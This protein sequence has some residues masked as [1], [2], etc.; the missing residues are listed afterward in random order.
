MNLFVRVGS[1]NPWQKISDRTRYYTFLKE[2]NFINQHSNSPF[3]LRPND[4]YNISF[5]IPSGS[6]FDWIILKGF[7]EDGKKVQNFIAI[8][9]SDGQIYDDPADGSIIQADIDLRNLKMS[10][11]EFIGNNGGTEAITSNKNYKFVF[12]GLKRGLFK[13]K[14]DLTGSRGTTSV[15]KNMFIIVK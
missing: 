15:K 9:A 10:S 5:S 2:R 13:F 8:Q 14:I 4:D 7:H 6:N 11:I 1:D 12:K 3:I